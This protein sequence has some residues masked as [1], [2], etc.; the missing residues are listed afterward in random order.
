MKTKNK[1]LAASNDM[2]TRKP[3]PNS[4]AIRAITRN[5]MAQRNMGM[6]SSRCFE[7]RLKEGLRCANGARFRSARGGSLRQALLTP[8]GK[9][10]AIREAGIFVALA[11]P[12]P[13]E[14]KP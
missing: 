13:S 4:D 7:V 11:V 12:S 5:T 8:L 6:S 9:E 14:T 1:I 3:K 10:L 2:L